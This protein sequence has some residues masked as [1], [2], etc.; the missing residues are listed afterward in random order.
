MAGPEEEKPNCG[1]DRSGLDEFIKYNGSAEKLQSCSKSIMGL[2][3]GQEEGGVFA[4]DRLVN[5]LG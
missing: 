5:T 2:Q 3:G 1:K 4:P